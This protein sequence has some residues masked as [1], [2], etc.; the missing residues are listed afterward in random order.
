[1]SRKT[2]TLEAPNGA[3]VR[4][5]NSRRFFVV[6]FGELSSKYNKATGEYDHFATPQA[7][8]RVEKR[9]DSALTAHKEAAGHRNTVVFE[10]VGDEPKLLDP[11][12]LGELAASA[13]AA[14]TAGL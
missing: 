12:R 14:R 11:Y 8:A 9:T 2:V 7:F 6:F 13:K 3:K 4:T 1:M 10:V 5:V